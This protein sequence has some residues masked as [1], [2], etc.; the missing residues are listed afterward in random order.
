MSDKEQEMMA[1]GL[2]NVG[3]AARFL[4]LSRSTIYQMMDRGDLRYAKIRK[5]RRIPRAAFVEL[6]AKCMVGGVS[7]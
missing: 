7:E 2:C 6:A 4:G 1:D 5:N 3:E